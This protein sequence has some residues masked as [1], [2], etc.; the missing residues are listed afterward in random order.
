MWALLDCTINVPE[1]VLAALVG[2][3]GSG[4]STLMNMAAGLTV[5]TAGALAY[6]RGPVS[7]AQRKSPVNSDTEVTEAAR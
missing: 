5:P 7:P 3:N 6:L 2:P 1:G 4:K